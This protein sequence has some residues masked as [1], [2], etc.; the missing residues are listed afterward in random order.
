MSVE[1]HP[2]GGAFLA[3]LQGDAVRGPRRWGGVWLLAA[4]AGGRKPASGLILRVKRA[5]ELGCL[6]VPGCPGGINPLS[7]N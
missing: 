6:A 3:L 7:K 5:C 1:P 2:I 4:S